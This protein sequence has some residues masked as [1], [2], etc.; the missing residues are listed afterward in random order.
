[1]AKNVTLPED[2]GL[3]LG[4]SRRG[5]TTIHGIQHSLLA[6]TGTVHMG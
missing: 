6:F 5:I 4:G 3:I 2:Q 1:M